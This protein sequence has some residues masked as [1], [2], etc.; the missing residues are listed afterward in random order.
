MAYLCC[1]EP[2]RKKLNGYGETSLFFGNNRLHIPVC[3]RMISSWARKVLSMAM[4]CMSL[5]TLQGVA[6][7]AALMAGVSLMSI[8][9]AGDLARISTPARHYFSTYITTTDQHQDSVQHSVL[10]L[11]ELSTCELVSNIDL[12]KVLQ[13]CWAVVALSVPRKY[14]PNCLCG[15]STRQLEL[16]LWG[17]RPNSPTSFS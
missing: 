17:A 6:A 1:T 8:M 12:C 3:D 10:G 16:L 13:I 15:I 7:S 11:R 14:F 5:C 2:F 9:P 4:A